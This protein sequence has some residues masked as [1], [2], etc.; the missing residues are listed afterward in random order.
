MPARLKCSCSSAG[1]VESWPFPCLNWRLS[2]PTT[3]PPRP[4]ATG[5]TGWREAIFSEFSG[6]PAAVT[7]ADRKLTMVQL[8]H[9]AIDF[10]PEFAPLVR[11]PRYPPNCERRFHKSARELH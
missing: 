10:A 7:H 3:P 5:I 9:L 2:T 8:I 1:T 4:L 6:G 11:D